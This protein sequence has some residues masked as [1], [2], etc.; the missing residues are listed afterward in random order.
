ML[1]Q[2]YQDASHIHIR[3][4]GARV[5]GARYL[6]LLGVTL[7]RQLHMGEHCAR[8]RKKVKPRV[9]QLCKLTERSCG[10][11]EPKLRTIAC[12]YVRGALK[13]AEPAWL[14]VTSE[15]HMELLQREMRSAARVVTGCPVSTP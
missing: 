3:V 8:L 2:R 11:Q 13:Y 9:A 14:P 15:S 1:S 12:G 6:H 4:D 5:P 10:L 7:N